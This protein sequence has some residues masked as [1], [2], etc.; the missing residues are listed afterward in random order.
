MKPSDRFR[1]MGLHFLAGHCDCPSP[2]LM[3]KCAAGLY[4]ELTQNPLSIAPDRCL[5]PVG[6]LINSAGFNG[7]VGLP[8]KPEVWEYWRDYS[9]LQRLPE[10]LD[11]EG[12]EIFAFNSFAKY[13]CLFSPW[14]G[15]ATLDY[16]RIV[17][18][19]L[20][21]YHDRIHEALLKAERA[22]A[23][24]EVEFYQALATV[25]AGVEAVA[26][27]YARAAEQLAAASPAEENPRPHR[28][29]RGLRQLVAG[30]PRDFFEAL[31]FVHFMNAVDGYDNVGRLDQNLFPF[32]ARDIANGTLT[33]E[34]AEGLLAEAFELWNSHHHWQVVVGGADADGRDVSNALTHV[35]LKA[36]GR[37]RCTQP[38]V[39][40]RLAVNSPQAL[41][42]SALD[43]LAQGVG[44]PA[45][46]N[47]DLYQRALRHLGVKA[48]DAADFVTGGCTE[49]HI[50]G[51]SAARDAFFN[52]AKGLEAV[53]YNGRVSADGPRFGV[54]TGPLDDLTT[55]RSFLAAY[56]KQA[57]YLIASFVRQRNQ[58][59]RVIAKYE[60]AL[61]RS[62]FIAGSI[63][64][65]VSNS[66]GGS[67]YDYGMVD[68]YGLPN[69]VNS[70]FAVRRLVYEEKSVSLAALAHAL[71][72]NFDGY[73][74]LRNLCLRLP[75][76]GNDDP[77]VDAIAS[78]VGEHAF[79]YVLRQRLW[80]GDGYYAFCASGGADH[81]RLGTTTGATPDG[82]L[83]G[84]PLANSMAATQGTD[85]KGPTA[86]LKSVAKMPLWKCMGSPVVNLSLNPQFLAKEQRGAIAALI[87]AFFRLGGMQL[88][89]TVTDEETLRDAMQHPEAHRSLMVRVSGYSARF[90]ELPPV[91]QEEIL[92]RTIH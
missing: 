88:Q 25:M 67:Q 48:E 70:L 22:H 51:K 84:T 61:I 35:I 81:V 92:S 4:E 15:H 30:P 65:G 9:F 13:Q 17:R 21:W 71:S 62:I 87:K 12:K 6:R 89:I 11:A 33:A 1:E 66:A 91:V 83:A 79:S 26:E 59:Q 5:A 68:M 78:D 60:P 82:R 75:K 28:L 40:V 18:S 73:E 3:L 7:M 54:E 20:A 19:G 27:R 44:Q 57:E 43:L 39:S 49:T 42:D 31:L 69:V 52:L 58:V 14:Q 23:E 8:D 46:Y 16:A 50:A 45:F 72:V 56:K 10:S 63:E 90:T 24:A 36:R 74:D 77:E 80:N 76:F 2:S 47:D 53:F 32:Y 37:A 38:S 41:L 29:A 85:L 55:F 64:T 34:E 86:M